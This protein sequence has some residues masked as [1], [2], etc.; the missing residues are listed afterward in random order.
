[1]GK[2]IWQTVK[3]VN[4]ELPR[5][6][7]ILDNKGVAH[8]SFRMRWWESPI[9]KTFEEM[10]FESKFKFPAYTIPKEIIPT[11]EPYQ[12]DAP[13]VFFGHYCRFK[14]PFVVRNNIC[15]LDSCVTNSK[16]L[17]AYSWDGELKLK[18]KHLISAI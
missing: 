6:L 10:S 15:C 11:Y 4:L 17:M 9:D 5:N 3:G 16:K 12:E 1:M 2:S 8:R 13:I 7:K 18:R 14:G